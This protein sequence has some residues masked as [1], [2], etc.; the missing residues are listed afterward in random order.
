MVTVR[1]LRTAPATSTATQTVPTGFSALPPPGPAIPVMLTPTS[2]PSRVRA[3][4][5]I[6]RA[7]ASLTAPDA[8]SVS[9]ETPRA[10]TFTAL[11]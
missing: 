6:S 4:V 11:S 9:G 7:T 5:A 8:A 3:P 10:A 2:A 1:W